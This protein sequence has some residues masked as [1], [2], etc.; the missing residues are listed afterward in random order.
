MNITITKQAAEDLGITDLVVMAEEVE[1]LKESNAIEGVYD[2]DSLMQA[3][4]AW[5]WLKAQKELTTW[6]ILKVHKILMLHQRLQPDEKGYLRQCEVSIGNRFGLNYVLVPDAIKEWC[7][8]AMN[9]IKVPGEE[10]NNIRIDHIE[11]ERIHP[12]VDGNGRTGR[13]FMNWQ[14]LKAG[15]PVLIIHEGEEQREYYRWFN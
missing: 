4:Y 3:V 13:M 15:L 1:F 9:S 10:G 5:S 6:V 2:N 7:K 12:F 11:Y 14:R 8:D